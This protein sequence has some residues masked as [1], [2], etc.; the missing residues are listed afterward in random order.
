VSPV[1]VQMWEGVSPVAVQ[2]WA[3]VSPVPVQTYHV[4]FELQPDPFT[5]HVRRGDARRVTI[6][7]LATIGFLRAMCVCVCVCVCV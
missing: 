3:G 1:A 4:V 2:M 6:V 7:I 5:I